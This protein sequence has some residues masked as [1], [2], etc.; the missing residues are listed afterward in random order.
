MNVPFCLWLGSLAALG[1]WLAKVCL[2]QRAVSRQQSCTFKVRPASQP[3]YRQLDHKLK[4]RLNLNRSLRKSS[5]QDLRE[6]AK[7]DKRKVWDF[8]LLLF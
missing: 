1:F 2:G 4:N 5:W 6:S 7:A 8:F 3:A